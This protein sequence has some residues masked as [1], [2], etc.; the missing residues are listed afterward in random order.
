M[1]N[2][3]EFP[4]KIKNRTTVWSRNSPSGIYPKKMKALTENIYVLPRSH[5]SIYNSQDMETTQCPLM[6]NENVEYIYTGKL[7]SHKKE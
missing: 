5:V 6:N 7:F 2:G 4:Q 3:M 1:E